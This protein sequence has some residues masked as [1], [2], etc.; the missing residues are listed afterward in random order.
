MVQNDLPIGCITVPQK[1]VG[2]KGYLEY[3]NGSFSNGVFVIWLPGGVVD[4]GWRGVGEGL[5]RGWGW[6]GE[7]LGG[8]EGWGRVDFKNPFEEP[9]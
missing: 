3:V 5:G 4:R 9:R 8:G 2:K 1:G 7:G 6:V